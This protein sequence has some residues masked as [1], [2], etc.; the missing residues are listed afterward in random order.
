MRLRTNG[1]I[2]ALQQLRADSP[3]RVPVAP[4]ACDVRIVLTY[5]PKDSS[6]LAAAVAELPDAATGVEATTI[7]SSLHVHGLRASPV[8][9]LGIG[10]DREQREGSD[11]N[12]EFDR[13]GEHRMT[14]ICIGQAL[15]WKGARENSDS[16]TSI[17]KAVM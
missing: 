10:A 6:P 5:C 17:A 1:S 2:S 15:E 11:S 13:V 7:H 14:P 12:C 8:N 3:V 4:H 16:E 9:V